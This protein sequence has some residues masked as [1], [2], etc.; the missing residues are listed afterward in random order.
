MHNMNQSPPLNNNVWNKDS[1]FNGKAQGSERKVEVPEDINPNQLI[2]DHQA[3]PTTIEL[4]KDKKFGFDLWEFVK[5]K[6]SGIFELR[7][8][9][10][11]GVRNLLSQ[12]N[13][14]KRYTSTKTSVTIQETSGIIDELTNTE[15]KD[16]VRQYVDDL[17]AD[18]WVTYQA[19]KFPVKRE[20]L[21]NVVL[22]QLNN[23]V[24]DHWLENLAIHDKPLL[25]D[26]KETCFFTFENGVVEVTQDNITFKQLTVYQD[27][28]EWKKRQI[29]R[30]FHFVDDYTDGQFYKFCVN[31]TNGIDGRFESLCTAIGQLLHNHRSATKNQAI[32]LYDEAPTTIEK[33]QGGTGKGLIASAIKQVRDTVKI[34]GKQY[35]SSDRFKF[36]N[37]EPSTQVAWFDD[38]SSGFDLKDLFS[39]LTDGWV[40][41]RKYQKKFFIEH[42]NSPNVLIC[43]NEILPHEG[44]SYERRQHII[45]LNDY[46]SSKIKPGE[47]NPVEAE[48]GLLFSDE[49]T[50]TDWN[51]FYSFMLV[52]AQTYLSKGLIPYEKRNVKM[53]YLRKKIS[54][55]EFFEYIEVNPIPE[56][57]DFEIKPLFDDFKETYL[58]AD[59]QFKQRTFTTYLKQYA[60]AICGRL[61]QK[62]SNSI[63]YYHLKK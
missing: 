24:N 12:Y 51:R 13:I 50:Q 15:I 61:E 49:W 47:I 8:I 25:Q 36:Q 10:Y 5:D 33:P 29:K 11:E 38:P 22:K 62:K 34:D 23:L 21:S 2:A 43:S 19:I 44:T 46:Y 14:K 37:I 28:C 17:T 55:P 41:E 42:Q 59:S 31:V 9:F 20:A 3:Y 32:I 16:A 4:I 7:S 54:T 40:I 18:V 57:K 27:Y 63:T 48:H 30:D 52:C 53:N 26:D 58:G 35:D 45:E 1:D 56:N 39:C 60:V 6:D